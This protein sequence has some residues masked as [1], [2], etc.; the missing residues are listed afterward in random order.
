MALAQESP[1]FREF[2]QSA[3]SLK[4]GP[5]ID[6]NFLLEVWTGADCDLNRALNHILDTD[7]SKVRRAGAGG[8][9]GGGGSVHSSHGS[10]HGSKHKKDKHKKEKRDSFGDESFASMG[11]PPQQQGPAGMMGMAGMMGDPNMGMM[12]A[13][14][15]PAGMMGMTDPSM[16]M[17]QPPQGAAGMMGGPNQGM[18]GGPNQ[19]M[20]GPNQGMGGNMGGFMGGPNMGQMGAPM[21]GPMGMYPNTDMN[22]QAGMSGMMAGQQMPIP[23]T[24]S[25]DSNPNMMGQQD[26]LAQQIRDTER[27]MAEMKEQ[28]QMAQMNMQGP[29]TGAMMQNSFASPSY[30]GNTGGDQWED[31]S[32]SGSEN[33]WWNQPVSYGHGT[34]SMP[35]SYNGTGMQGGAMGGNFNSGGM[36]GYGGMDPYATQPGFQGGPGGMPGGMDPYATQPGYQGGPGGYGGLD[37]MQ[38]GMNYG[39]GPQMGMGGGPP[40]PGM[41]A[42]GGQ[43]YWG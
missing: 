17:M 18:M 20:G 8:G 11:P 38:G 41:M 35:G 26:Q 9:G 2:C 10:G 4:G 33:D 37:G 43:Q 7:D 27:Q 1:Q 28:I 22:A 25:F 16:G 36:Q 6:K 19:G 3:Q 40:M 15:G 21:S 5:E 29:P 42:G 31:E 14:Q 23:P 24:P 34:Q 30:G 12:Q 32:D 13:P 39:G